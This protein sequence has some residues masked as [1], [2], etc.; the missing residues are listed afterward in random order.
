MIGVTK[1]GEAIMSAPLPGA[2]TP[3]ELKKLVP[4]LRSLIEGRPVGVKLAATHD[5]E[6]ELAI[7]LEAG[8]DIVAIDGCQGGTHSSPPI[9]A[10]DFGI[11]TLYALRRAVL[12]MEQSGSRQAVSLVISGG[13]RTP[14]EYLKALAL[15]ADAIYVGTAAMMAAT[16]GSLSQVVP[17]EPITQLAWATGKKAQEFDLEKGAETVSNFLAACAGEMAEAARALGKQ[18]IRDVSREDLIALDLETA[19]TLGLSAAWHAPSHMRMKGA[20]P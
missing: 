8:V 3:A 11:P 7:V 16:H 19:Q 17:F 10:D 5:L 12:F 18:R 15:G 4:E 6:R 9:I 14:G 1:G 13:L 2:A 20:H